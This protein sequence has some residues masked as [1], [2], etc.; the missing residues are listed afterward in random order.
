MRIGV[1]C[2]PVGLVPFD[3]LEGVCVAI[4]DQLRE[5]CA[6]WNLDD[7]TVEPSRARSDPAN[8]CYVTVSRNPLLSTAF[9]DPGDDD[10]SPSGEHGPGISGA[11]FA[12]VRHDVD[13]PVQHHWWTVTLSHECIEMAVNPNMDEFVPAPPR[14]EFAALPG[15]GGDGTVEYLK[16]IC[17]PCQSGLYAYPWAGA[18]VDEPI[19]LSDFLLPGYFDARSSADRFSFKGSVRQPLDILTHGCLT[20]GVRST[21]QM[22]QQWRLGDGTLTDPRPVALEWPEPRQ[23]PG[24]PAPERR[25]SLRHDLYGDADYRANRI[26]DA[27]RVAD[28]RAALAGGRTT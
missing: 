12:H 13:D 21:R 1:F 28:A 19:W 10:A 18:G 5:V 24:A 17:D 6:A 2:E 14:P 23:E 25:T 22:W 4:Q 16:E 27:K 11:P 20:W 8:V 9:R 3:H 26:P 7:V 15:V